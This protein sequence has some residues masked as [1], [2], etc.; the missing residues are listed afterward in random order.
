MNRGVHFNQVVERNRI[1][2]A[3]S[4]N[5]G[6]AQAAITQTLSDFGCLDITYALSR[7]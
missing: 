6:A 5:V 7:F 1:G 4:L 2:A 3:D